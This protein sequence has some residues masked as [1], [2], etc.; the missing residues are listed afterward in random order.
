MHQGGGGGG[1]FGGMMGGGM[2]GLNAGGMRSPNMDNLTDEG[3]SGR[4]YDNKV[5]MRLATYVKPYKRDTAISL[6]AVLIYTIG[7]VSIPLFYHVRHQLGHRRRQPGT[8]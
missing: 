6:A 7:N 4:A 3:R 5:V 8:S 1:G 2:R